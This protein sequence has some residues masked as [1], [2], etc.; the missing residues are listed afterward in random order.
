[1]CIWGVAGVVV[2]EPSLLVDV[3]IHRCYSSVI[4]HTINSR[5]LAKPNKKA[6]VLF[7]PGLLQI[8][9]KQ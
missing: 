9:K 6:L 5:A 3:L 7:G 1:L 8:L 4:D 2:G